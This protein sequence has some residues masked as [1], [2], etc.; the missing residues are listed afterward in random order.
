ME[1]FPNKFKLVLMKKTSAGL[2]EAKRLRIDPL[3]KERDYRK[4]KYEYDLSEV[5]HRKGRTYFIYKDM[6]DKTTL[7][8]NKLPS[9]TDADDPDS[10]MFE[11]LIRIALAA[12][13]QD[14]GLMMLII[15]GVLGLF[16]GIILGQLLGP[17]FG[18]G[19]PVK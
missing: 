5:S 6:D 12:V 1:L 3:K 2:M 8:F 7:S 19:A 16:G 18:G 11:R 15:V 10:K 14:Y 9:G 17:M 13:G 4:V